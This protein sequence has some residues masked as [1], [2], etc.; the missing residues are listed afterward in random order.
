MAPV[1]I[2]QADVK[3]EMVEAMI[4]NIKKDLQNESYL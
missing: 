1:H 3:S 4:E 2:I